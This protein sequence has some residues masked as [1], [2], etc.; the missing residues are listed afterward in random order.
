MRAQFLL[1]KKMAAKFKET[2]W[3][4]LSSYLWNKA[5]ST[6]GSVK[7]VLY[8]LFCIL[9]ISAAGPWSEVD[10]GW[11]SPMFLKALAIFSITLTA[12]TLADVIIGDVSDKEERVKPDVLRFVYLC[13]AGV[14]I[15]IAMHYVIAAKYEWLAYFSAIL[16]LIFWWIVNASNPSLNPDVAGGNIANP[17]SPTLEEKDEDSDYIT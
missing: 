15:T 14:T 16:T 1:F 13:F 11:K 7:F 9:G 10:N 12:A 3:A 2:E 4:G 5:N 17:T 6:W 8:F